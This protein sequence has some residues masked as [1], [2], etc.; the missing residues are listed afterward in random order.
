MIIDHTNKADE[1]KMI[2]VLVDNVWVPAMA[3]ALKII[4]TD[5]E[6]KTVKEIK[7]RDLN[8]ED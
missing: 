1:N 4:T 5:L 2:E 6:V 3:T 7:V 8:L